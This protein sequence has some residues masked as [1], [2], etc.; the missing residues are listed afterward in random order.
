MEYRP[1]TQLQI[2]E[3]F[4]RDACVVR[5]GHFV[6]TGG[7]HGSVYIRKD[8]LLSDTRRARRLV[9]ELGR[10]ILERD[11]DQGVQAVIGPEKSGIVMAHRVAD[12][13]DDMPNWSDDEHRVYAYYAEKEKRDSDGQEIFVIRRD[14]PKAIKDR[15]VLIAEDIINEGRTSQRVLEA[16]ML[17]GGT[18]VGVVAL[19]NRGPHRKIVLP[20]PGSKRKVEIPIVALIEEQLDAWRPADCPLC[21]ADMP[22]NISLGHGASFMKAHA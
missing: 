22:I 10:K 6:Y 13:L 3:E 16:V 15:R 20:M 21:A 11:L 2:R 7:K 18:V 9:I 17:A 19:W 14:F 12:Y 8:I 4:E 5:D 1:L